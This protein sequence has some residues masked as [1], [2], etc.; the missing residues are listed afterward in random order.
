MNT[1][2]KLPDS[3]FNKK[4]SSYYYKY[5]FEFL[6][7]ILGSK[8]SI[9]PKRNKVFNRQQNLIQEELKELKELESKNKTTK[10]NSL[11]R[12]DYVMAIKKLRAKI[13]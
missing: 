7:E 3:F 8:T 9:S 10:V 6:I 12:R 1:N 13:R 4:H 2:I 5:L 11:E